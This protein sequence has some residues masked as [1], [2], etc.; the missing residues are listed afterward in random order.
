MTC[1]DSRGL[2]LPSSDESQRRR[3]ASACDMGSG[4]RIHVHAMA[5]LGR[6]SAAV[7]PFRTETWPLKPTGKPGSLEAIFSFLLV[8]SFSVCVDPKIP[9]EASLVSSRVLRAGVTDHPALRAWCQVSVCVCVRVCVCVCA[10]A[11]VLVCVLVIAC[12]RATESVCRCAFVSVISLLFI[13]VRIHTYIHICIYRY[14]IY[15]LQNSI[16]IYTYIYGYVEGSVRVC[17]AV[18]LRNLERSRSPRG[19]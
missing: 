7:G 15:H 19:L 14:N 17:H 2:S 4:R 12:D 13:Y 8:N 1:T 5:A 10:C 6:K 11:C 18:K 3:P 9:I 16:S